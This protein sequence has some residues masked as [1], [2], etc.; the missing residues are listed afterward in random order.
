MQ[1]V[2]VAKEPVKTVWVDLPFFVDLLLFN[3]LWD[4]SMSESGFVG[5]PTAKKW[6]ICKKIFAS[7]KYFKEIH[8]TFKIHN[9]HFL[10]F[11]NKIYHTCLFLGF[12]AGSLGFL[13]WAFHSNWTFRG[14]CVLTISEILCGS[15][16]TPS[17]IQIKWPLQKANKLLKACMQHME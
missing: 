5:F 3:G 4:C 8:L 6:F 9:C 13:I 11:Y 12:A 14:A 16:W 15:R 2:F 17:G 7:H 1:L 10:C